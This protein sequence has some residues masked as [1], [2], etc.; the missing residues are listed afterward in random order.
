[1]TQLNQLQKVRAIFKPHSLDTLKPE[2]LP[3]VGVEGVFSAD[4][5]RDKDEMFAGQWAFGIPFR[6]KEW[7]DFPA[8]WLPECDL[9]ILEVLS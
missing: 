6:S 1:M 7:Q 8:A 4:Y 2:C 9:E 5:I 3:W